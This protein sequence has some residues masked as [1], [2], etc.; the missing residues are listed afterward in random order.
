MYQILLSLLFLILSGLYLLAAQKLTFG[1]L[2]SPKSGFLPII[3]GSAALLLSFIIL[4][5]KLINYRKTTELD[6]VNWTK[7]VFII[8]GFLFY[9]VILD[10]LGYLVSTFIMILYMLKI[11]ETSEWTVSL[12][13]SATVAM[14][15]YL[16]FEQLLGVNLP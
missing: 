7:F 14:T 12:S 8:I 5:D 11:T 9:V 2:E 6:K 1:I 13:I 15:S 4:T 10:Y 3:A 16:L